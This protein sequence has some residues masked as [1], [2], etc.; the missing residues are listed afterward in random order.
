[1]YLELCPENA[2]NWFCGLAI[3]V[4]I[5]AGTHSFTTLP[6]SNTVGFSFSPRVIIA[7]TLV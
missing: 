2:M 4:S 7:K 3:S 1:M 6:M 5:V